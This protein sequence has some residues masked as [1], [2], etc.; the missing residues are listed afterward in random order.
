[1]KGLL[2][3]AAAILGMLLCSSSAMAQCSGGNCSVGFRGMRVFRVRH[4][5]HTHVNAD[6]VH[7]YRGGRLFGRTRFFDGDGRPLLKAN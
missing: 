7:A 2:I 3:A 6:H 1:M 5:E 4:V